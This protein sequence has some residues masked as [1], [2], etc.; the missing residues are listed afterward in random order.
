MSLPFVAL[1]LTTTGPDPRRDRVTA[2]SAVTVDADGE[3]TR[4]DAVVRIK[5]TS[6]DR[7]HP[8]LEV[9][10]GQPLEADWPEIAAEL[11]D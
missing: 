1:A 2:V 6:A 9:T 8:A 10:E 7:P 3:R 11:R 4:F 5:A